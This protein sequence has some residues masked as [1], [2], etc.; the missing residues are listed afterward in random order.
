MFSLKTL[1]NFAL[2]KLE[3]RLLCNCVHANLF[4]VHQIFL[5]LSFKGGKMTYD[6]GVMLEFD[7]S[8]V[9]Y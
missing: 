6:L 3:D 2:I 5:S 7:R 8:N 4:Q 1:F 9:G